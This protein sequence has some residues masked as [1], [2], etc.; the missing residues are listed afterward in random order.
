MAPCDIFV[1]H[2]ETFSLIRHN[3]PAA[4]Q[5]AQ[6][7]IFERK[8]FRKLIR[9]DFQVFDR[10]TNWRS[11]KGQKE[12]RE[13]KNEYRYGVEKCWWINFTISEDREGCTKT[14]MCT[15]QKSWCHFVAKRAQE[16]LQIQKLHMLQVHSHHRETKS[17]GRT[18][19]LTFYNVTFQMNFHSFSELKYISGCPQET[20]S[21]RRCNRSRIENATFWFVNRI[22]KTWLFGTRSSF[23]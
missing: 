11:K 16:K 9:L 5:F 12:V 4:G 8:S 13:V 3:L 23:S 15:M 19:N 21:S 14:K 17:N 6:I 2:F 22:A 7:E 20:A 18:G 10:F 1:A